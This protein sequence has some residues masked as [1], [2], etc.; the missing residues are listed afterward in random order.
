MAPDRVSQKAVHLHWRTAR[1]WVQVLF[2]GV[3]ILLFIG[4]RR[5]SWA[6]WIINLPMRLDPL[7]MLANTLASRS[8]LS[9]SL[10]A[11]LTLLL[12]IILGRVWC[13]WICPL[14]SLLDLFNFHS[15]K[16]R[17]IN[18]AEG[19]RLVKYSLLVAVLTAAIF[20]NLSLLVFDPITLLWRSLSASLWPALDTAVSAVEKTLFAIPFLQDPITAFDGG[21]RPLVFPQTPALYRDGALYAL[22]FFGIL[23]LN[24]FTP[25]FWCRYLCPLGAFLGLISKVSIFHRQVNESCKSCGVC[26][27][28]CPTA[29]I[30][31][32]RQFASDPGECIVCMDCIDDCP[33]QSN[34]FVAGFGMAR[35]N[36]YDPSRRQ[37]IGL[38]G[39][40][41]VG[42]A[43][44]QS[45]VDPN[46]PQPHLI[47]PPGARENGLLE[48]C[49]RC[50]ECSRACPTNAIQPATG[51]AG[52]VGLWTPVLITRLGYCDYS[53]N[54][55]GQVCPV[56]AIPPLSLADK[57]TKILGV[58][59]IDQNRCIAWAQ[60]KPCIVCEEMCPVP[61]KAITL[62][63]PPSS[64]GSPIPDRLRVPRV[65]TDQCIGCGICE[66]RCP[67][68]G[69]AAIRIYSVKWHGSLEA[70]ELL[71]TPETT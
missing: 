38:I 17:V 52:L 19:W 71:D 33:R 45:P 24:V 15:G 59:V 3:F 8:W 18:P 63:K 28:N 42:V 26:A 41:V 39:A 10:L 5:G 29:T 36:T 57:R 65:L 16:K 66:Y 48:K 2:F 11:L 21:I 32:N 49:I 9:S 43:L 27:A 6:P 50:G 14:G 67:V 53:C 34:T 55:C 58:A 68:G 4:A 62:E 22:V 46:H 30:D 35:W 23:G 7:T 47:Q 44:A 60:H 61:E 54:A 40:T 25:R 1:K 13:G 51:E 31:P 12:T 64:D 37:V 20:A 56:Q 69:E 70:K